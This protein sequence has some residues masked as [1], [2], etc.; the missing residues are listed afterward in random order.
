MPISSQGY[1][2]II[3]GA[4]SAGCALANRLSERPDVSVLLLE[5]GPRDHSI[6]LKMPSA[7][8]HAINSRKYDW[9]FMGDPEPYLD[10]RQLHCP[11][12]RVLG[13]S[14]SINAMSF[15]R[16]NPLDF[17]LW[18][19]STGF[20]DWAYEK[21]LPYFKKLETFSGGESQFRGG[22]GPVSVIVPE[23]SNP[24]CEV[25]ADAIR[26]AG[27]RWN[28]DVNGERQNGFGPMD[29]TIRNGRRESAATAYLKPAWHRKNLHVE[30]NSTVSRILL[31][32]NR[33]DGVEIISEGRNRLIRCRQ[34]IILSAGAIESPKLLMLSGIGPAEHLREHG[35]NLIQHLPGVGRNLQDHVNV[36]IQY[37]C[38]QP[39]THT[40][41]LK[42]YRKALVGLQWLLANN[43]PGA[44]NHFE[45]AGYIKS[46]TG[47]DRPDLQLLFIP[48]L[49]DESGQA[50]EQPHG[51]QVAA[52]L[53][54]SNS[55]GKI[56]L[57]SSRPSDPPS[58]V[59]NYLESA[60]DYEELRCGIEKTREIFRTDA[61]IPY[62]GNEI[63]PGVSVSKNRQL[64]LFIR[65][66]LRSTKHPCGTCRMGQDD[67]S[68]VDHQGR[69]HGVN[70][71]RVVD[72]SIMPDI[73][74]GNTNAPTIMIAEKIA[75]H[76]LGNTPLP[77]DPGVP[78]NA[79]Q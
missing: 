40:P 44:T 9:N 50:S 61:F 4:G 59:F 47:I 33:V 5:A 2:Y 16:G 24:L 27:Y 46:Q 67:S 26:E 51:F 77:P 7:F 12:G 6:F 74:S 72:A 68:V 66:S 39:I 53:L 15:V 23:F 64:D 78:N 54:R 3:V 75:D 79:R 65:Q 55:R 52:S 14:S 31:D 28:P 76:L 57:K 10:H 1:D 32:G 35:I 8:A 41:L 70:A 20:A 71:L 30:C 69:V 22:T 56:E 49:V 62:V 11:R 42:P 21:C 60:L 34:E 19:K 17:D 13:G 38:T 73:T 48:L 63:T 18:A 43:G 58:I 25:F 45:I 36:N 37:G 29:Q